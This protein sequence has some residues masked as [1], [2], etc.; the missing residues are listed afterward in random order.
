MCNRCRN[1]TQFSFQTV[2]NEP[3]EPRRNDAD[4]G[5]ANDEVPV[6]EDSHDEADSS[7]ISTSQ[8]GISNAVKSTPDDEQPSTSGVTLN[9]KTSGN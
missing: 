3:A 8:R 2:S 5:P 4:E 9:G 1:L 6:G 7:E